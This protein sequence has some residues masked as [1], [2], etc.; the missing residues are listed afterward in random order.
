LIPGG[1]MRRYSASPL[2]RKFWGQL[3]KQLKFNFNL[4]ASLDISYSNLQ[5][6]AL[7]FWKICHH[8]CLSFLFRSL[9]LSF[10]NFFF[11]NK[12]LN[13]H[14]LI[15]N[16]ELGNNKVWISWQRIMNLQRPIIRV[17]IYLCGS[18]FCKIVLNMHIVMGWLDRQ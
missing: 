13:D 18:Y 15:L 9:V 10:D 17:S 4:F 14:I 16:V 1:N 7:R 8:H 11:L 3:T 6:W 12:S 2:V 5:N